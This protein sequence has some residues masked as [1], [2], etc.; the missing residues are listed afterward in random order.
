M[1]LNLKIENETS[2]NKNNKCKLGNSKDDEWDLL[3]TDDIKQLDKIHQPSWAPT[4]D[5]YVSVSF[6]KLFDIDTVNQRFT[7]EAIVETKW[8]DPGIKSS[9]ERICEKEIWKPEL[10]FENGIKDIREEITYTVVPFSTIGWNTSNDVSENKYMI[11]EMRKVTGVFYENLELEDFPSDVQDLTIH[12]A[13]RRP[14]NIVNFIIT[15]D[16]KQNE[17]IRSMLDESMWTLKKNVLIRKDTILRELSTGTRI[18]PVVR[19]SLKVFRHAGFFMWNALLPFLLV[20]LA[21][22]APFVNDIKYPATRL[23]ATCTLILT[24]VSIR[25]TIGRLLPTVSYLTSLDKYSL[26]TMFIIVMELFY[27]AIM[28]AIFPR[29]SDETFAYKI[30]FFMF[31]F[32]FVIIITQQVLFIIWVLKVNRYRRDIKKGKITGLNDE[33]IRKNKSK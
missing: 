33:I 19:Y 3:E 22:L 26:A 4:V 29:I 2:M 17:S 30:D 32:F 23:P 7:A 27:H 8:V 1:S 9:N 10:Y 25:F 5:I 28:G 12:V 15:G 13:S 20:T 14:G 11:C 31:C 21:S 18:Y 24:S 6:T 16:N